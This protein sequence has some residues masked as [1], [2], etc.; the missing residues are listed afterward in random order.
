LLGRLLG[1]RKGASVPEIAPRE[2][3]ERTLA[4]EAVLVDVWEDSEWD[5][6]R[7]PTS[8]HVPL[9][10]IRRR[11]SRGLPEDKQIVLV[12]RSGARSALAA[13]MLSEGDALRTVNLA[14]GLQAWVREGLPF[15]ATSE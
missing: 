11:G 15:E 7:I 2:A 10:Q 13:A 5:K 9:S 1:T 6:G 12:C 8:I 14:G 4:G 3:N